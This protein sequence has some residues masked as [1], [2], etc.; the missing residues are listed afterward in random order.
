MDV[1]RFFNY[2]GDYVKNP[3]YKKGNGQP[4]YIT[5]V[6]ANPKVV[7]G[8]LTN[9]A[10]LPTV[11]NPDKTSDRLARGML[12]HNLPLRRED[13]INNN[14]NNIL[15]ESQ[16]GIEQ[17][18][19]SLI[20]MA[21]EVTLGTVKGFADLFD[22]LIYNRLRDNIDYQNPVSSLLEN[23]QEAI[24]EDIAPVYA[25]QSK[26]V[27]NG[28]LLDSG[29]I[30]QG[31]PS[32]M[33][34]LT[35]MIPSRALTLGGAKAIRFLGNK[36]VGWLR[37]AEQANRAITD[38]E[39]LSKAAKLDMFLNDANAFRRTKE[40]AEF[41]VGGFASRLLENYQEAR[42][43]YRDSKGI[44]REIWDK[45]DTAQRE[46]AIERLKDEN[47]VDAVNWENEDEVIDLVSRNAADKTFVDDLWNIL[48]VQLLEDS[49]ELNFKT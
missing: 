11:F 24:R 48:V 22:M 19:N 23:W 21:S 3:N 6:D 8:V 10:D 37:K 25:D 9:T 27:F 41:G 49:K 34:S 26:N 43:T 29:F 28:G 18:K 20:Q 32:I 36:G 42:Q 39:K 45:M 13:Y 38:G 35:L 33:S 40:F 46:A 44:Y 17:A 14:F 5:S 12:E 4:K 31:L 7:S 2:G 47:G 16:S 1:N 30:F 15:A